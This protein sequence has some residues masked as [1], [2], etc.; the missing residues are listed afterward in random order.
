[1]IRRTRAAKAAALTAIL[2]LLA[3]LGLV[4][5]PSTAQA[6]TNPPLPST[7]GL[8]VAVVMDASGSIAPVDF[9]RQKVAAKG[10]VTVLEG[11]PSGAG[12]YFFA[13]DAQSSN[14]LSLTSIASNAGANTVR[15]HI[16]GVVQTGG[17]TNWAAGFSQVPN[18][19]YDVIVF[20]TDGYPNDL[21]AGVAQA[22][23]HK[24]AGTTVLAVGVGFANESALQAIS[25]PVKDSDY[26]L[27]DNFDALESTLRD[28]AYA[29][30]QGSVTVVKE[31][32]DDEGN[33][34]DQKA[35]WTFNSNGTPTS[36]QTDANGALNFTLAYGPNDTTKNATITEV[37]KNGWDLLP[38]NGD[39]ATCTS[40]KTGQSVS[41]TNVANG[42]T[43]AVD[44]ADVVSCKVIN[45][46]KP[47]Q[48][49]IQQ[50]ITPSFV[51]DYDWTLEK[52]LAQGE[53]DTKTVPV[54][55]S[56]S[57]DYVVTA[58]PTHTDSGWT[59]HGSFSVSNPSAVA[60]NG[61]VNHGAPPGV[62][63]SAPQN[64]AV[65]P[66]GA[67]GGNFTCTAATKPAAGNI[68]SV[69]S[70]SMSGAANDSD[71]YD[72]DSVTPT[73]TGSEVTIED[74]LLGTTWTADAADGVF[75]K[76]YTLTHQ[77]SQLGCVPYV[78]TAS[79]D[80][81]IVPAG[82]KPAVVPDSK[83]QTVTVCGTALDV[84]ITNT[85]SGDF[86]RDHDW[87][88]TKTVD[89]TNVLVNVGSEGSATYTLTATPSTTDSNFRLTGT[90]VVT[91]DNA[92][93][94]ADVTVTVTVAEG[95]CVVVDGAGLTIAADSSVTL[96]YTCTLTGVAA[97][98]TVTTVA[99]VVWDGDADPTTTESV[100]ESADVDFG[101][102]V[103]AETDAEVV[104]TDDL[105]NLSETL[106]AV[107]GPVV[108]T[109]DLVW[110]PA[111]AGCVAYPNTAQLTDDGVPVSDTATVTVCAVDKPVTLP[112]TGTAAGWSSLLAG[113]GLG[114]VLIAASRVRRRV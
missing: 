29:Q 73:T 72:F 102:V 12:I 10:L 92:V 88:L 46:L 114:G 45:K 108:I 59:I 80:E 96:D 66:G 95:T 65:P 58:T 11:T 53:V 4:L 106:K 21:S 47:P 76:T 109:Y 22:D 32:Q 82:L 8:D 104:L 70:W 93:E 74:D 54:G 34:I 97:G 90:A 31:T 84:S 83:S 91:N 78:N 37:V 67:V 20:I 94:I 87:T 61:S 107:D 18:G 30:C 28:I 9:T 100:D 55:S 86:D 71:A 27:I 17:T 60:V 43:V 77:A 1:M 3:M 89:K 38:Q 51:R 113:L 42:F 19:T 23:L 26:F 35:G 50:T 15:N 49:T 99:T 98:D 24:T 5:N 75:S 111:Q 56:A 69:V 44:K 85:A 63:C 16:D 41:V 62:N 105:G 13:S 14:A 33:V 101:A 36:G 39:N 2:S 81:R 7:C 64:V 110:T 6:V 68:I 112:D 79:I 103:P 25:G 52:S 48:L 40:R 57:F